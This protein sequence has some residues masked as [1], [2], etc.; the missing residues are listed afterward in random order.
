VLAPSRRTEDAPQ[1]VDRLATLSGFRDREVLDVSLASTLRDLLEPRQVLVWRCV[2]QPGDE[3]W[4]MRAR[5]GL[6][7]RVALSD[8]PGVRLEE[9]PPLASQPDRWQC[10]Q[11]R[12]ITQTALPEGGS[13]SRFPLAT[14]RDLVGVLELHTP[15]PLNA[16]EQRMVASVLRL[17]G[18]VL[19]LLDYSERDTLTG[20]LNRKTFDESF[21]RMAGQVDDA[22][23]ETHPAVEALAPMPLA[24]RHAARSSVWLAMID[25]D[26]F[27]RV[28]DGHGHLIGDEVLLLVSRLLRNCFRFD[29]QLYRFGGEEF[30]VL[31]RCE[32][33][34]D[35]A[36]AFERLRSHVEGFAF[37][38]VGGVTVSVGFT[39]VRRGDTPNLAFER[40]D[41]AVYHAKQN[42]RNQVHEHAALVA[43]GQL[44]DSARDSDIE[45]F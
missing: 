4:L 23:A 33:A 18:N 35:A 17:Y 14:D 26:H 13:C 11:Q 41:Q 45:L 16:A 44:Q 43:A 9:L 2:G 12:T 19:G 38:R 36:T 5:L 31:M 30:V 32:A 25:I 29:D 37:P 24:R 27:K 20:L 6:N 10:L 21:M 7:D 3:R 34:A 28:N 15:L 1:W 40:A 22:V 39:R 8:S 42:G